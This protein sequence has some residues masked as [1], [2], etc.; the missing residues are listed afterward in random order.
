MNNFAVIS[1]VHANV[2]ALTAVLEDIKLMSPGR[3]ICLGDIVGYGPEPKK[4]LSLVRRNCDIVVK[5]NHDQAAIEYPEGF[6][7]IA[8]EAIVWTKKSLK[9]LRLFSSE[10]RLNWRF[11]SQLPEL[12]SED[13]MLFLHGSPRNPICEYIDE[14]DTFDIYPS[15]REKLDDI[16]CMIDHLC[17][18]GHTHIPGIFTEDY[19]FIHPEELESDFIVAPDKKFIIN[20][21][22][23]GQPRDAFCEASY[24]LYRDGRITYR[25]VEYD[26]SDTYNKIISNPSLSNFLADRLNRGE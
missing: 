13:G 23:V 3:I 6:N 5:G 1:D 7:K 4:A 22:S 18:C 24:V 11:L 12:Y 25:R 10:V 14:D 2:A 8:H 9:S 17:F 20:V 21:G 26:V 16:F 19:Q 15:G